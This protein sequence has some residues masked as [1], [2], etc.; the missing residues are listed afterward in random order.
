MKII[1]LSIFS[2]LTCP[3]ATL[4][5]RNYSQLQ[6]EDRSAKTLSRI[7][8]QTQIRHWTDPNSRERYPSHPQ[9]LLLHLETLAQKVQ[10]RNALDL[11]ASSVGS[12]GVAVAVD[13]SFEAAEVAVVA[14]VAV[15]WT[16]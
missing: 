12:A 14:V 13:G 3:H 5:S 9:P 6:K 16:V 7:P 1:I 2:L 8:S 4:T 11:L 10:D 15:A